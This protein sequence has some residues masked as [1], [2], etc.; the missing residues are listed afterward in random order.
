VRTGVMNDA[1]A[2]PLMCSRVSFMT[3]WQARWCAHGR[4]ETP[5]QPVDLRTGVMNDAPT[6]TTIPRKNRD[7]HY[8]T[9]TNLARN[10]LI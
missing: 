3:P 8:Q 5:W 6:P 1:L 9:P 2:S 7:P 4:H 10:M